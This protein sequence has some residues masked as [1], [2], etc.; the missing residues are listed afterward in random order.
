MIQEFFSASAQSTLRYQIIDGEGPLL[1]MIHGL[2]CTGLL[3]YS[4]AA[5]MPPADTI[6]QKTFHASRSLRRLTLH[7][8]QQ[9]G[10]FPQVLHAAQ[11]LSALHCLLISR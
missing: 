3:D 4:Q 1:I 7:L 2:G 10:T 6:S 8:R 11:Y 9:L 5:L